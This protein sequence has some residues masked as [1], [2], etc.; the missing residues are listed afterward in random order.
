[1]ISI[2]NKKKISSYKL[3]K[4]RNQDKVFV[5]EGEKMV[6]ELLETNLEIKTIC[7][8]KQFILENKSLLENYQTKKESYNFSMEEKK[9]EEFNLFE[10]TLGELE[11]ISSLKTPNNVLAIIGFMEEKEVVFK[12]KL[13]LIL[14]DISNPGNLGTIIRIA[15]WFNIENIICSLNTVDKYNPKVI[16]ASMG[17]I[18]RVNIIYRDLLSLISSLKDSLSIY[19][20]LVNEGE[21]IY[22]ADLK[23]EGLIVIGSESFGINEKLI[24]YINNPINI[25][26]FNSENKA[27][28]LNASV[29]T[30][31]I[32]SEFQRKRF[33]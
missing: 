32:V 3:S 27:E 4:F 11:Q 21:N 15:N 16:Q 31:I 23:D 28:S 29:A 25:P 14:D 7:A 5:V 22:K 2:T 6:K 20:A 26:N 19:G 30:G 9:N 10:V 12:E 24:P 33:L 8:T 13:T 1:M 17:S 18:F